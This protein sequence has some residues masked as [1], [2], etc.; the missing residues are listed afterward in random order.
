MNIFKISKVDIETAKKFTKHGFVIRIGQS[1]L[2]ILKPEFKGKEETGKYLFFSRDRN[3]LI[4]T[5]QE[6]MEKYKL[7]CAKVPSENYKVGEDWVLC[8]Y[9]VGPRF[10]NDLRV[11]QSEDLKY[12]YWKSD[13][14][15]A[16]GK[17]SQKFIE[18]NSKQKTLF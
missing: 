1:W 13:K 14:D 5:A 17:Y 9:D 11:Y 2:W 16:E 8:I 10:K 12:R 6:I 7:Y 18:A 4:E 3:K 15:T